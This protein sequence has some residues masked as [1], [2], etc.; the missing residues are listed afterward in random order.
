MKVVRKRYP[1]LVLKENYVQK[2]EINRLEEQSAI[3]S[4]NNCRE[5]NRKLI[6]M[7]KETIHHWS[8]VK[9]YKRMF[10]DVSCYVSLVDFVVRL[11]TYSNSGKL[12]SIE[13]RRQ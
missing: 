13:E 1:I 6:E 11:I 4:A 5:L 8:Y 12:I 10:K 9:T 3:I 2:W 7:E